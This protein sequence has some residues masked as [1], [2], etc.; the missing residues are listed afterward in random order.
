MSAAGNSEQRNLPKMYRPELRHTEHQLELQIDG[1]TRSQTHEAGDQGANDEDQPRRASCTLE[2]P[3][4]GVTTKGSVEW[5][6]PVEPR[7][8]VVLAADGRPKEMEL[9]KRFGA[10][11]IVRESQMQDTEDLHHWD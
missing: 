1:K 9:S 8:Q 2:M 6:F 7:R 5:G 3:R 4:P 10:Q 11:R